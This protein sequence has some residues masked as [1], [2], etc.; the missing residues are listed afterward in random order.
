MNEAGII[1]IVVAAVAVMI[2]IAVIQQ[3]QARKRRDALAALAGSLGWAF[4][5]GKDYSPGDGQTAFRIFNRGDDRYAYNTLRGVVEIDGRACPVATGDYHYEET[6]GSGKDRR[7]TDYF[8]SYVLVR[9][10][11]VT[12][13]LV[14]R[15]EGI[16]DKL[17][18]AL[19][20]DDI[21]FE[22]AEFSRRFHVKSSDKRFAYDVIDPRMMEWL[23]AL[24]RL[25]LDVHG[26]VLCVST[27]SG[28]WTPGEFR[29]RL[30]Y[31]YEF[32][33]RW[34]EHVKATLRGG[35]TSG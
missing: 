18:G 21:D 25:P 33:S 34:P 3:R 13:D 9:L 26:G 8:F 11:W 6:H 24:R 29:E 32:L 35:V 17:A 5:S 15:P 7:T 16:F 10:P 14:I 1:L 12:P 19:G 30:N 27:G 2:L 23:M 20:F 4:E 31:A 28:T 22:S